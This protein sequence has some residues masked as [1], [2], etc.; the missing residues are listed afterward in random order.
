M[1]AALHYLRVRVRATA[2]A[3]AIAVMGY[4]VLAAAASALEPGVFASPGSPAGREYA[5]PLPTAR[6]QGA[7]RSVTPGQ[8]GPL[9]GI[10]ITPPNGVAQVRANHS[11]LGAHGGR[12]HPASSPTASQGASGNNPVSKQELATL[13]NHGS[14][15]PQVALWGGLVLLGGLAIGGLLA[16]LRRRRSS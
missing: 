16:F 7:G 15:V 8:P 9:F 5:L 2:V 10:G 6:G 3:L 12:R 11:R 14:A 1:M 4:A 13:T